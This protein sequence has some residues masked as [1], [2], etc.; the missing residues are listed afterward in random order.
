V[1]AVELGGSQTTI[2]LVDNQGKVQHRCQA[3][4]LRGRPAGATLD[5][6]LRAIDGLLAIAEREHVQICGI[7]VSV[8][9]SLDHTLR[10]P[11]FTP[12]LP[13]FNNFPLGDFLETRY[14]LPVRLL[15]DVDAAVLGEQRFGAGRGCH[16]L[17][18]LTINAVV[19]AALIIDGRLESTA[20]QYVGH[21]SHLSVAAS[22]PRCSCGKRG[23]INTLVSLDAVQR[24][25]QRALRRGDESCLTQRLLNHEC[26][27]LQLLAEEALRGDSVALQIYNE[28]GRWLGAAIVKYIGL[29]D[30][31]VLILS[32]NILYVHQ[33]ACALLLTQVRSVL[34]TDTTSR[35][36]SMVEVVPACLG[37]D[38]ALLG[39]ASAFF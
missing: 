8:P 33:D 1:V 17:L 7:G 21:V 26:F 12:T 25:V 14:A 38:A 32:G 19:G 24:M 36:C 23:C 30:P 3:K 37:D 29:F 22:G 34:D 11:L 5:P 27:S 2:A 31:H 20:Q 35:V 9:G 10:R 28:I 18:Y 39:T 6:Y 16:R 13:S 4:T 15:V